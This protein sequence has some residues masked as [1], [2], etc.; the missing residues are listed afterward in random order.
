MI[1]VMFCVSVV[2]F[3]RPPQFCSPIVLVVLFV[4]VMLCVMLLVVY[5]VAVTFIVCGVSY[6]FPVPFCINSVSVIVVVFPLLAVSCEFTELLL[7]LYIVAF[8]F[9]VMFV[10]FFTVMS[11][12]HC[13]VTFPV[14]SES[15]SMS[16]LL[17]VTFVKLVF[18]VATFMSVEFV[19]VMLPWLNMFVFVFPE[20]MYVPYAT[21][22]FVV[23]IVL[24]LNVLF[25][26]S[27]YIPYPLCPDV[28]ILLLLMV[29]LL[30]VDCRYSPYPLVPVVVIVFP[31][32]A[33]WSD[34]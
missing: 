22:V 14:E 2:L 19:A 9:A 18:P 25:D 20:F 21:V 6:V 13:I 8:A 24:L 11:S 33:S 16:F 7:M 31:L 17:N 4:C 30:D 1:V 34:V 32:M 3:Q 28:V 10:S 15:T 5:P 27:R 29:L 23:R 12:S 26:D